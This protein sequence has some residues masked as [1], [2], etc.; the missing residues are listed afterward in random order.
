MTIALFSKFD[1]EA[2][3]R[4]GE[5]AAA[6]DIVRLVDLVGVPAAL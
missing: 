6:Y 4:C 3:H 5:R 2:P 1:A